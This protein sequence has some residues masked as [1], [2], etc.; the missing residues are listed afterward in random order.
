MLST[1]M[2]GDHD[3]SLAGPA[4]YKKSV[5]TGGVGRSQINENASNLFQMSIAQNHYNHVN[6]RDR[7]RSHVLES[8]TSLK[9]FNQSDAGSMRMGSVQKPVL[10]DFESSRKNRSPI[11]YGQKVPDAP[12]D[13][14]GARIDLKKQFNTTKP[15]GRP[16]VAKKTTG[17]LLR[18]YETTSSLRQ[19]GAKRKERQFTTVSADP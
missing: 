8:M 12:V 6:E 19:S 5:F 9:S 16:S 15:T 14:T 1:N 11:R 4:G 3:Q 18:E 2:Q 13:I 17:R 7:N 10:Y